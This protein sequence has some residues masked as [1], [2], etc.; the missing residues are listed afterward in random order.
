MDVAPVLSEREGAASFDDDDEPRFLVE[1]LVGLAV[2]VV[3]VGVILSA[4]HPDLLVRNTTAN[5]GDMGAHVWW[6]AFLRDHWFNHFRLAGWAPDWYAGFPVGQ[7]YFPLPALLI[8]L[9]AIVM[10]YDIAFKL[11]TVSGPL[12][13]PIAAY[14]FARSLRFPW[15]S[16]P[17]FALA[18]LRYVFETRNGAFAK[19][20]DAW[21]IYGGNLASTLAGEFS[22]VLGISLGLFFLAAL[23]PRARDAPSPLAA[24]RAARGHGAVPHR[25]RDVRRGRAASRCG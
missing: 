6:P 10:P 19:G 9:L 17:L 21:T 1:D 7:F 14:T 16:P 24:C 22:Y 13:L 8:D 25:H 12:L 3:C 2:V 11:V 18:T 23:S 4:L 20:D 5:G 15:P